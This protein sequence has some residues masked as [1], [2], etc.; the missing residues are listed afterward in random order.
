MYGEGVMAKT[1]VLFFLSLR[2]TRECFIS[3]VFLYCSTERCFFS[4]ILHAAMLFMVILGFF[5]VF[6]GVVFFGTKNQKILFFSV[7]SRFLGKSGGRSR[8]CLHA[9]VTIFLHLS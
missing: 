2:L 8:C 4:C 7:L 3:L 6:L 1:F 5:W 9:V